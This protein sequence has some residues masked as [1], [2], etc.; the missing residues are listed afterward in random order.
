MAE[1]IIST[2]I[3]D[4][5]KFKSVFSRSVCLD[6]IFLSLKNTSYSHEMNNKNVKE[7]RGGGG[8]EF[9]F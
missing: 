1:N 7:G 4:D 9:L 3:Y 6:I 2:S 8:I 5:T